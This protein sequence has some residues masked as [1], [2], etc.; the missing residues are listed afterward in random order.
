ME[1]WVWITMMYK[2]L[3]HTQQQ[4]VCAH[5]VEPRLSEPLKYVKMEEPP[6]QTSHKSA[7]VADSPPKLVM[8][9]MK[10]TTSQMIE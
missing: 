1:P 9:I 10:L 2:P 3:N 4:R 8:N 5:T 6:L 7:C